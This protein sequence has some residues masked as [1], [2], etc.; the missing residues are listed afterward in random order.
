[1]KTMHVPS[2]VLN[3]NESVSNASMQHN[4]ILLVL[5]GTGVVAAPQ[6]LSHAASA[7]SFGT[8]PTRP[9]PIKSAISVVY[10]CRRDDV[11]MTTD[12]AQ[13]CT[14]TEENEAKLQRCVL[15]ISPPAPNHTDAPAPFATHPPVSA[16]ELDAL[17]SF[18][19]VSVVERRVVRGDTAGHS[20]ND[21]AWHTWHGTAAVSPQPS[22]RRVALPAYQSI[23]SASANHTR[24]GR[25]DE[26]DS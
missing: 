6:V 7:T 24:T 22:T 1:M 25:K 13:W 2:L 14:A 12:I 5:A 16:E 9:P 17:S 4:G 23:T 18:E 26:C 11:C 8:S 10:A 21:L 20:T 3:I 19:N 15:A